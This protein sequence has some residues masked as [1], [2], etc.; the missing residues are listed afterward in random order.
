M[1]IR[2]WSIE[3]YGIFHEEECRGLGKGLTVVL[4]PNESGKSTLIDFVRGVLFGFPDRR[5]REPQHLPLHGGRHGGRLFL[6]TADGPL[7]LAREAGRFHPPE[8]T[9]AHGGSGDGAELD[10][11]LGGLDLAVFR[12]VFAFGLAELS[13]FSGLGANGISQRLLSAGITGAGRSARDALDSLADQAAS[14][15]RP[16]GRSVIGDTLQQLSLLED[17][18]AAARSELATY[19]ELVRDEEDQ[20]VELERLSRE[21][22]RLRREEKRLERLLDLWPSW[23]QRRQALQRLALLPVPEEDEDPRQRLNRLADRLENETVRDDT[24]CEDAAPAWNPPAGLAPL[25]LLLSAAAAAGLVWRL[26]AGDLPAALLL[27]LGAVS[28]TLVSMW[29]ARRRFMTRRREAEERERRDAATMANLAAAARDLAG[30]R[31]TLAR[32]SERQALEQTV[33]Q[34]DD[35]LANRAGGDQRAAAFIKDLD[36]GSVDTWDE[37][38]AGTRETLAET[39][40]LRDQAIRATEALGRQREAME[41]SADLPALETETGA[42]RCR[43]DEQ[44]EEWRLLVMARGLVEQALQEYTAG[45]Q[46]AVLER[47]SRLFGKV[48]GGRYEKVV[49]EPGSDDLTLLARDGQRIGTRELSRGT[50][51]QLYLCL[52]LALAE[53]FSE[54]GRPMPLLMDDVLVNADPERAAGLA[55]AIREYA[56][57]G[58]VLL[59]TC[60][61][62]TA[63]LLESAGGTE[64]QRLANPFPLED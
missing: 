20:R 11:I 5:S 55:A 53:D 31:Q 8:L 45:R 49:Q 6:E 63:D 16:R 7:V 62:R 27:A 44:T 21:A 57:G 4:G 46:P 1:I 23:H 34:V 17:R 38:L 58:Q 15:L 59:F 25:L 12:N 29:L 60:H 30:L 37:D 50:A 54:R 35:L 42:L 51:E 18:I 36:S 24:L 10:E 9:L 28:G 52:R 13:D 41:R 32:A 56:Q 2:G 33:R 40:Q 48:T 43:L 14:Q 19:P 22:D 61:P 47:A 3:G 26:R 64:I 39:I